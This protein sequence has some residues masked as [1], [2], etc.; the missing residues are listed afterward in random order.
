MLGD[1]V[2]DKAVKLMYRGSEI[3]AKTVNRLIKKYIT[4]LQEEKFGKQSIKRL[5][6]KG[7]TIDSIP[8]FNKDLR[9]LQ[10][11]FKK[12]GIDYSVRK[13]LSEKSTYEV[14]FKGSDINQINTSLKNYATK[15]LK[16]KSIKERIERAKVK[17]KEIAINKPREKEIEKGAR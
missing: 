16:E 11:E 15:N 2:Q 12:F 5:S 14:Y 8:V 10:R 13:S 4:Q 17:A 3:S 6:R 1:D 7:K 9:G